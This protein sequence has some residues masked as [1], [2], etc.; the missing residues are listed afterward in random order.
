MGKSPGLRQGLYAV[1]SRHV[2]NPEPNAMATSSWLWHSCVGRH[3]GSEQRP[4]HSAT[5]HTNVAKNVD[6]NTDILGALICH[7][8]THVADLS[9]VGLWSHV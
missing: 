5:C 3:S 9:N 2:H 1:R 6:L 7:N 4:R 8:A